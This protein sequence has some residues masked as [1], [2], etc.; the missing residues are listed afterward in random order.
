MTQLSRHF[1]LSEFT[2]SATAQARKIDNTA[3]PAVVKNLFLLAQ[4]IEQ[5]RT[6]LN[7][8][9]IFISSGYRCPALNKAV[10]GAATSSHLTGLACDFT[11][12][13]FGTPFAICQQLAKSDL[14]FDQL[15]YERTS[16]AIWAH[17]GIAASGVTPRR[18]V[19]TIDG[20]G[21]RVGLWE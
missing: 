14:M 8:A 21:T 11:V 2:R 6:E 19:L 20:N 1:M 12:P 3:P 18:Q 16:T 9:A 4:F 10:G 7:D 15:I 5:V 17:C 13:H